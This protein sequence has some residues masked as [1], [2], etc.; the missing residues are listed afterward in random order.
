M[1]FVLFVLPVVLF[2][3][4]ADEVLEHETLPFDEAV[5]HAIHG[6]S[7]TAFDPVVIALTNIGGP[8]GATIV[9]AVIALLLLAAKQRRKFLLVVG[10]VGGATLLNLV[11]KAVFQR[12]RP[13][14]WERLVTENSYSFPSG[15]AMAS[16]ALALALIVAFW[17]TKWRWWVTAGALLYMTGIAFTRMYLGV[18]YPTD[19]AAGW[20]VSAAWV[21]LV[22]AYVLKWRKP[23]KK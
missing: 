17:H 5:L 8:L 2:V 11:L 14:L 23:T 3:N 15:H 12:D 7:H 18:H 10:S 16:S 21:A 19:I 6:M 1:M 9:T 22:S 13:Q 4:L 20:L